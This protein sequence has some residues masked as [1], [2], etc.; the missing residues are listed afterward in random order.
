MLINHHKNWHH[1]FILSPP[2]PPLPHSPLSP[3]LMCWFSLRL[4]TPNFCKPEPKVI[5]IV[6][7]ITSFK[8]KKLIG[9][10]LNSIQV[11][12]LVTLIQL[13]WFNTGKCW[14]Y[15]IWLLRAWDCVMTMEQFNYLICIIF[16]SCPIFLCIWFLSNILSS[17]LFSAKN[18]QVTCLSPES[19]NGKIFL[20]FFVYLRLIV[21][22]FFLM[23]LM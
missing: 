7:C 18:F 8:K 13:S 19:R 17:V 5:F 12:E 14:T 9:N 10:K 2:P 3:P 23:E 11:C 16:L 1:L 15:A 4:F 20:C 21:F 6:I 22:V